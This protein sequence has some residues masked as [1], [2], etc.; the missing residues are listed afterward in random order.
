MGGMV[1]VVVV[2]EVVEVVVGEGM[3]VDVTGAGTVGAVVFV[4]ILPWVVQPVQLTASIDK[5]IVRVTLRMQ[6]SVPANCSF[7]GFS[8]AKKRRV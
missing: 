7:A 1:V 8:H 3:V 5:L 2:V 4:A 6:G